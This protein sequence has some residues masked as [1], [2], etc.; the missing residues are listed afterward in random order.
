MISAAG[1]STPLSTAALW[2]V[3]VAHIDLGGD[4][5]PVETLDQVGGLGGSSGVVGGIRST[6]SM[7]LNVDGDDV[8]ALQA[9]RT[10]WLRP[11]PARR[12]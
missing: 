3:V 7:G 2:C 12:R 10:A 1:C 6:V 4:D 5:P 8:G 9:S 11:C